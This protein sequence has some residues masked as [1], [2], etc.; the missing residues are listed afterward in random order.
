LTESDRRKVEQSLLASIE[1]EEEPTSR[2]Q[3]IPVD[4]YPES[5]G[6]VNGNSDDKKNFDHHVGDDDDDVV[7]DAPIYLIICLKNLSLA[8]LQYHCNLKF[9]R[10]AF[11]Q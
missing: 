3:H 9:S 10:T 6:N 1:N 7:D 8:Q 11:P 4:I 2:A 5:G